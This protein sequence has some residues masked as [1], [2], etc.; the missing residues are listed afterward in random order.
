MC[1][2][3]CWWVLFHPLAQF[4]SRLKWLH[5]LPEFIVELELSHLFIVK[6]SNK[7][8]NFSPLPDRKGKIKLEKNIEGKHHLKLINK[9]WVELSFLCPNSA[10]LSCDVVFWTK[11][12]TWILSYTNILGDIK[13]LVLGVPRREIPHVKLV[14]SLTIY[15]NTWFLRHRRKPNVSWSFLRSL[16]I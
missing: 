9:W 3:S 12:V 4:I 7:V 15:G 6:Y 13:Y 11:K 14:S 2:Q 10:K 8:D 16:L 5:L 1:Y